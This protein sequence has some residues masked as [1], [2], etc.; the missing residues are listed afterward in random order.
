[1]TTNENPAAVRVCAIADIQC[2]RGCGTGAC[3][4]EAESL[5][6]AAAPADLQGLRRSILTSREIV[7]DQD[8]MLSHPAVPYL[9]EDVNYE[10]FFA[11]FGIEA[12]FIHMEDDVDC[13]TY[14]RYF[15]SNSP[16]CCTWTPSSPQ[17]DGWMLLEIY[18]TEDGPVALY[19]REKKPESMR[20]RWK[21]EKRESDAAAPSPAD[22]RAA[23]WYCC[24]PVQICSAQCDSCAKQARA[25][26]EIA[27]ERAKCIAWANA[28][29]FM[30][31]HESMCA[32]WEERARRAAQQLSTE[33]GELKAKLVSYELEREDQIR[34]LAA[35]SEEIAGLK[36]QLAHADARVGLT[37]EQR[38]AIDF[39]IGWYEQSTIADNPYREHIAALRALLSARPAESWQVEIDAYKR[40]VRELEAVLRI[41]EKIEDD[42]IRADVHSPTEAGIPHDDD[43]LAWNNDPGFA[44]IISASF[45]SP[46]FPEYTHWKK[47]PEA[48]ADI[49]HAKGVDHAE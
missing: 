28:N 49:D 15:A 7:R 39:V 30:K 4:R 37:D 34:Y 17:G 22:E 32:A 35:Q 21:R 46:S 12:T 2:S 29:G 11:A 43:V 18:D 1:M 25:A 33:I 47:K 42:W 6:P 27:D 14:D 20:E 41:P 36:Q 31:Y 26:T 9:D 16:D 10:T 40:E 8:G 23:S 5:Q 24:D 13:D 45:I 38:D 19:V 44:T 48:P 3:K